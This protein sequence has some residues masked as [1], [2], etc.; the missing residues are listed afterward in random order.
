MKFNDFTTKGSK[1]NSFRGMVLLSIIVL[2]INVLFRIN[3]YA[4]PKTTDVGF[5]P[6]YILSAS[7]LKDTDWACLWLFADW[8]ER[9]DIRSAQR[10]SYQGHAK[11][12][13]LSK[14]ARDIG[15]YKIKYNCFD[16]RVPSVL[17][18]A[19]R[20]EN[21]IPV[22]GPYILQCNPLTENVKIVRR[23]VQDDFPLDDA[24]LPIRQAGTC[25]PRPG[26]TQTPLQSVAVPAGGTGCL[27][28]EVRERLAQLTAI[29]M[30]EDEHSGGSVAVGEGPINSHAQWISL[31]EVGTSNHRFVS[32]LPLASIPVDHT[33]RT[34]SVYRACAKQSPGYSNARLFLISV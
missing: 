13:L 1:A 4:L 14:H 27:T 32:D 6:D 3:V 5:P 11:P 10:M 7:I 18:H 17:N 21:E 19:I 20:Y 28:A 16:N 34:R 29:L 2:S 31:Q 8:V 30:E 23:P 24:A 15:A 25:V 22:N 9:S 26:V 12:I 33:H